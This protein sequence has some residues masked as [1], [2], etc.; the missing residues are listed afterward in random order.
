[1]YHPVAVTEVSYREVFDLEQEQ[2]DKEGS[3]A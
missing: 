1:M 2:N 3:S